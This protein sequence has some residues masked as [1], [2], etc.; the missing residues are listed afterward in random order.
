MRLIKSF[1]D[2]Y[3]SAVGH[4]YDPN[5][6]Y[7]RKE[8]VHFLRHTGDWR[9]GYEDFGNLP[10]GSR[11]SYLNID[12]RIIGFCGVLY[13]LVRATETE[14]NAPY[15]DTT[16]FFYTY[17]DYQ[18]WRRQWDADWSGR[19][20]KE[21]FLKFAGKQMDE[22]FVEIDAPVFIVEDRRPKGDKAQGYFLRA[23]SRLAVVANPCLKDWGFGK[24]KDAYTAFQDISQYIGNQLVKERQVEVVADKYRIVGHGFDK[25]SF[26]HPVRLKDL[27]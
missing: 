21:F 6:V 11:G 3:D 5:I 23:G 10:N 14:H 4:G 18:A 19:D 24:V 17:E 16:S 9:K 26:R 1:K 8:S 25:Y 12:F 7:V 22:K 20:S 2:Y 27:K 13:P 15:T